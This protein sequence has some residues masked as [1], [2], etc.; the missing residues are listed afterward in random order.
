MIGAMYDKRV[1][2]TNGKKTPL[3]SAFWEHTVVTHTCGIATD[4]ATYRLEAT[5]RERK[6]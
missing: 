5:F 6:V 3:Q 1:M 2:L 4:V